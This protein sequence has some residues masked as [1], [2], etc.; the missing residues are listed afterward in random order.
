MIQVFDSTYIG[1]R[2]WA[3]ELDERSKWCLDNCSGY[4]TYDV[5]S[6]SVRWEFTEKEDAMAFKLRWI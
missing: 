3:E 6:L 2:S 4:F 5:L 1:S